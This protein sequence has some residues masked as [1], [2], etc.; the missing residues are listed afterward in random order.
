MSWLSKLAFWR[1][2]EPQQAVI[3]QVDGYEVDGCFVPSDA[4]PD[5]TPLNSEAWEIPELG[6][7]SQPNAGPH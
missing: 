2:D 7:I 3:E 1:D 6:T 5:T 4:E